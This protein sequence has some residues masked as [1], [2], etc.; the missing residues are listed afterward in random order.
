MATKKK[1]SFP[2]TLF[3][4]NYSGNPLDAS[5]LGEKLSDVL[6]DNDGYYGDPFE[7]GADV[8]VAEYKLISSRS[9]SVKETRTVE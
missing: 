2:A 8:D 7:E 1:S 3:V 5:H 4:V 9:G 6:S